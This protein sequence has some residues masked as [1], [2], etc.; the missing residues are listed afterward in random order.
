M[1]ASSP[2]P[3]ISFLPFHNW[4]LVHVSSWYTCCW[5]HHWCFWHALSTFTLSNL[6]RTVFQIIF[7]EH[8]IS[9]SC[10]APGMDSVSTVYTFTLFEH[11]QNL[12]GTLSCCQYREM[13]LLVD[14]IVLCSAVIFE[15]FF[16]A[17]TNSFTGR[18]H[19][20]SLNFEMSTNTWLRY[21]LPA[22]LQLFRDLL[23]IIFTLRR[24]PAGCVVLIVSYSPP[25][26][27]TTYLIQ[28][29]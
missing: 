26:R 19:I 9:K 24:I 4:M 6:I 25:M 2:S 16:G 14:I 20:P 10:R 1:E 11:D 12:V 28:R 27:E 8:A 29:V 13:R 5:N 7:K 22:I 17:W 23:C 3:M 18:S 21:Q 15:G